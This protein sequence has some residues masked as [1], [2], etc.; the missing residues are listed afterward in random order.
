MEN[1]G[2]FA[3]YGFLFQ[4]KAFIYFAINNIKPNQAVVFEGKD[5]IEV[6]SEESLFYMKMPG[7]A[8]IQVKSGTVD[9]QCFCKIIC[10]WLL[11][12]SNSRH[13]LLLEKALTFSTDKSLVDSI[14][15]F[16]DAGKTKKR[17]S[18]ARRTYEKY[19]S[20]FPENITSF[21][22][23]ISSLLS[24]Y[25]QVIFG[26][27]DLDRKLEEVFFSNYC[28]D[29]TEYTLAKS[30]R[31]ERFIIYLFH[32]IDKAIS[33]K[34]PYMLIFPDFMKYIT[35]VASEISDNRYVTN[36]PELKKKV[37]NEATRIVKEKTTR[38]VTQLYTVNKSDEFVID[39]I[40]HK[41]LYNDFREVYA[42]Q[43]T[44]ELDNI[45]DDAHE[46][47]LNVLFSLEDE[48][49]CVPKRVFQE[50]VKMPISGTLLP[51]GIVYR[52]G[53]YIYLTGE[54]I[55]D[56]KKISWSIDDGKK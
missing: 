38:E 36:V 5:D 39:G 30:K 35:Q 42:E 53:C 3:Q 33:E 41:L 44:I 23:I 2:I 55:A 13:I 6:S 47:Y 51:N 7:P 21:I 54:N 20:Y 40:V 45:E 48:D 4:R 22:P 37:K 46:N 16:I 26:M 50:T 24:S 18:I 49:A 32:D 1:A 12:D 17:T 43:K 34:K 29:I 8:T 9:E 28:K 31:L 14:I 15:G 52:K 10:N 19:R 27:D 25:E 56:E 11:D